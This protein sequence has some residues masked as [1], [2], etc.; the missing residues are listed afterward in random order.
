MDGDIF[1]VSA[2]GHRQHKKVGKP[3][4]L[5]NAIQYSHWSGDRMVSS[6]RV[7][8]YLTFS[9]YLVVSGLFDVT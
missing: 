1:P 3:F 7:Y 5:Q 9:H 2:M 4:L 8:I 6:Q